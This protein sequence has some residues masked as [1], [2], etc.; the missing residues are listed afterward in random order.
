MST[1][2]KITIRPIEQA[3]YDQWY[4]MWKGKDGY[5]AFY[6]A[7]DKV[8]ENV[9]IITFK[10]F[11]NPDEPMYALVATD[12]SGQL[13]GFAHYLTH[14]NTWTVEPALYL[15][16]LFVARNTRLGGIGRKLIEAVYEE[17]DRLGAK[18]CYWSTQFENHRAQMLY[19]KVA[20]KSGFLLYRRPMA[21]E[22]PDGGQL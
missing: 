8:D 2:Q 1:E 12:S 16:D 3:D 9:S 17:A 7:L 22:S 11:L 21:G 15:N 13:I 5:L 19:V 14:G 4:E 6:K 18:K 10:R 20:K